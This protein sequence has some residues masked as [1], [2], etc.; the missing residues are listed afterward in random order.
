MAA[1]TA[2]DQALVASM[3]TSKKR[4]QRDV[5]HLMMCFTSTPKL[6]DPLKH[7]RIDSFFL[8]LASLLLKSKVWNGDIRS[9]LPHTG[10]HRLA[11]I[12]HERLGLIH[13][14]WCEASFFIHCNHF[15]TKAGLRNPHQIES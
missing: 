3:R 6:K 2:H 10:L 7:D 15:T 8:L 14:N 9:N 13:P 5:L 11:G 1:P 4:S 12:A